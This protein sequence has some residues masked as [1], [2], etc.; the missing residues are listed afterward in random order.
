MATMLQITNRLTRN[1]AQWNDHNSAVSQKTVF[2]LQ[3]NKET[4]I[5]TTAQKVRESFI[6]FPSSPNNEEPQHRA[7]IKIH[8]RVDKLLYMIGNVLTTFDH[9]IEWKQFI[10]FIEE[11]GKGWI[12]LWQW[13]SNK[14]QAGASSS[15]HFRLIVSL[16]LSGVLLS[17][18]CSSILG[19]NVFSL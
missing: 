6:V 19:H 10:W 18:H 2:W 11:H 16:L 15:S 8:R 3:T 17:M 12:V 1:I 4:K 14:N 7:K 9:N 13:R 5:I